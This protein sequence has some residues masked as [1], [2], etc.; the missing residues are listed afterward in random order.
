MANDITMSERAL[1]MKAEL[2]QRRKQAQR[3]V[4]SDILHLTKELTSEVIDKQTALKIAVAAVTAVHGANA[5]DDLGTE[6][7]GA[8]L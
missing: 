1:E 6:I 8:V 4:A 3:R 5:L 7:A 2:E